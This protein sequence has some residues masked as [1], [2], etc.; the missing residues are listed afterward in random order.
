LDLV[1]NISNMMQ[2]TI[3]IDH[4]ERDPFPN[5][6]VCLISQMMIR[7]IGMGSITHISGVVT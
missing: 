4:S 7:A 1:F 3:G 6:F 5:I 2:L